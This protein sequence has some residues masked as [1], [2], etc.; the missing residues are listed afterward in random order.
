MS[1]NTPNTNGHTHNAGVPPAP[2]EAHQKAGFATAG[3]ARRHAVARSTSKTPY[4][5]HIKAFIPNHERSGHFL[6]Y[7]GTFDSS[8]PI[9]GGEALD[10]TLKN[11]AD[12]FRAHTG[13]HVS[14]GDFTLVSLALVKSPDAVVGFSDLVPD[15]Q[16]GIDSHE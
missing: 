15:D 16:A 9:N 1:A 2:S 4:C 8:F 14:P 13:I 3:K 5:Y 11:L 6:S 12:H 10:M 7:D